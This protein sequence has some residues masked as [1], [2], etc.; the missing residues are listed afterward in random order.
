MEKLVLISDLK[1]KESPSKVKYDF[2]YEISEFA[3]TSGSNL[4][5]SPDMN[6]PKSLPINEIQ[7]EYNN[8]HITNL[9]IVYFEAD[10]NKKES[11]SAR[12]S[13]SK[14]S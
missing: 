13:T 6:S 9:I 4:N 11:V 1:P 7:V 10:K 14:T 8:D 2:D 3:G 12:D 5:P